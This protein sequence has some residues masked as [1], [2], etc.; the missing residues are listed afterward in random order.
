MERVQR[1]YPTKRRRYNDDIPPF[2]QPEEGRNIAVAEI[3]GLIVGFIAWKIEM[4]PDQRGVNL[5][6][7]AASHGG[8]RG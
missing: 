4:K 5:L 2:H 7:A 3:E 8:K 6:E 1:E